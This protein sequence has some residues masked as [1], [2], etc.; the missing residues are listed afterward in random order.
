MRHNPVKF[1]MTSDPE[2][3]KNLKNLPGR[4]IIAITDVKS[5]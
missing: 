1:K 5:K 4:N 3:L 2:V